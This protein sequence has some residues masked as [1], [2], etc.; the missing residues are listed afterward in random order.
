[1]AD[2]KAAGTCNGSST[3][4]A[5][6]EVSASFSRAE[7]RSIAELCNGRVDDDVLPATRDSAGSR[8]PAALPEHAAS[9]GTLHASAAL[10]SLTDQSVYSARVRS[11]GQAFRECMPD[12]VKQLDCVAW[13]LPQTAEYAVYAR[14]SANE[15][16]GI[17]DALP[18]SNPSAFGAGAGRA[19][20]KARSAGTS[21]GSAAG[22]GA[23]AVGSN[24]ASSGGWAPSTGAA[25]AAGGAGS[26]SFTAVTGAESSSASSRDGGCAA[27]RRPHESRVEITAVEQHLADRAPAQRLHLEERCRWQGS[28]A[29]CARWYGADAAD[30]SSRS[31]RGGGRRKGQ[32]R[33]GRSCHR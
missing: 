22:A 24:A 8:A 13:W 2:S 19:T 21:A 16:G 14:E 28:P 27:A 18:S 23:S 29:G 25:I 9:S 17:S 12:S 20:S 31:C 7:W 33:R 5:S 4:S 15:A 30:G 6:A 11:F 1:V 26:S 32:R 3:V 10:R